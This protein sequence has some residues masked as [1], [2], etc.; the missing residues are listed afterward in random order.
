MLS[1]TIMPHPWS[2]FLT[3]AFMLA[4]MDLFPFAASAKED[5]THVPI[6]VLV[7]TAG[8]SLGVLALTRPL[9]AVGVGLPFVLHGL[10]VLIRGTRRQRIY[11]LA[12]AILVLTPR[13]LCK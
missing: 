13:V 4:W 5:R 10:I 2:L 8:L 12:T 11:A 6:W 7:L 1:G 9:T 3:L